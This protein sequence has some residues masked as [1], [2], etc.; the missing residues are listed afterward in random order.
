MEILGRFRWFVLVHFSETCCRIFE[1]FFGFWRWWRIF[2]GF[3]CGFLFGFFPRTR[4][5]FLEHFFFN[6]SWFGLKSLKCCCFFSR[7]QKPRGAFVIAKSSFFEGLE[8]LFFVLLC[9]GKLFWRLRFSDVN[10][11]RWIS[12]WRTWPI[13]C[14]WIREWNGAS[15]WRIFLC[16]N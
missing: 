1:R 15:G 4:V 14:L 10:L 7:F 6:F 5:N 2:Q 8:A 11:K 16:L 9:W 13:G 3:L 12:G